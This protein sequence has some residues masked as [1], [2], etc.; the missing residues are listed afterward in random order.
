MEMPFAFR[1][2]QGELD[3]FK[4]NTPFNRAGRAAVAKAMGDAWTSFA[5]S[6]APSLPDG[7]NWQRRASGWQ[8]DSLVI[9]SPAGGD[10]RMEMLRS[11]VCAVKEALRRSLDASSGM[12]RCRIYARAFLWSP[13]FARQGNRDEYAQWCEEFGCSA[14]AHVFRPAMEV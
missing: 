12:S 6:G 7:F 10:L 9:D 14:P 1:D 2:T 13:I 8:P 4:V 5:R 3:L 11:D